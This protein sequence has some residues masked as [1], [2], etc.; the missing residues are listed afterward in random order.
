MVAKYLAL[1]QC[2]VFILLGVCNLLI[3]LSVLAVYELVHFLLAAEVEDD[4]A[5][6][7]VAV[8]TVHIAYL[9]DVRSLR[10]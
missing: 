1:K 3:D 8:R 6:K 2:P 9:L 10:T 5:V 4:G 7:F